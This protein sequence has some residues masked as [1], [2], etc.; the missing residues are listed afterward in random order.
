[1]AQRGTNDWKHLK[2][3]LDNKAHT[4]EHLQV[5][6]SRRLFSINVRIDLKLLHS[7]HQK[8]SENREVLRAIIKVLLFSAR[9]N[10]A[11]RG[12]NESFMSQNQGNTNNAVLI[13]K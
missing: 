6:I 3:N 8:I 13:L 4:T 11:L 12:H 9:Q 7:N 10:I 2:R 5:E 1:L